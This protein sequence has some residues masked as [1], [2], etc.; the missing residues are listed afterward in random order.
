MSAAHGDTRT[1]SR[2]PNR[3]IVAAAVTGV[4]ILVAAIAAGRPSYIALAPAPLVA[5]LLWQSAMARLAFVVVGGLF[6]F[7]SNTNHLTVGKAAFFAG[8]VL[9]V[10]SIVREPQL[11]RDLRTDSTI[12]ALLPVTVALAVLVIVTSPVARSMHTGLSP[13]LRDAAAYCLAAAVPLLLWDCDRNAGARL[14]RLA[15]MLLLVCGILSGL[16]LVVQWLGQRAIV[17]SKTTLHILPSIFLPGALALVLAVHAG[18]A[19]KGRGWY[20]LGALAIP[21]ILVLAGTRSAIPVFVCVLLALFAGWE[22]KRRLLV[23]T[24]G[25]VAAAGVVLAAMVGVAHVEHGGLEKLTR[26]ITSI[27]HTLL[28]LGSDQSYLERA[29]EWHVAWVTFKA[30][31]L[32]GVGPGH[33]FV[34][35]YSGS[36]PLHTLARYNLDSPVVFLAK[37]GALG[38]VA[39]V[40]VILGLIRF[41][42][43]K[44]PPALHEAKLALT[45]YLVLAVLHLPFDWPLEEKDFTLGL[46]LLGAL[47]V[48]RA[49]DTGGGFE[50]D[51][52]AAANGIAVLRRRLTNRRSTT[53]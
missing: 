42:R 14:T 19:A 50:G 33:T 35:R 18:R 10:A 9:V 24:A 4:V 38:V 53:A 43:M 31:P 21:I 5:W 3:A 7:V 23:W 25:G 28:H 12:R 41:L 36:G 44:R 11:Y 40:V 47:A 27:P 51:W 1:D 30:H 16:A 13:W 29:K 20:T 39:L 46:I 37:F 15:R 22:D 49:V 17:S 48:P 34:W 26:R 6:V 2:R 52:A 45:W 8:L 32:L